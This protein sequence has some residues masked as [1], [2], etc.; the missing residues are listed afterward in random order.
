MRSPLFRAGHIPCASANGLPSH[1][2]R[3]QAHTEWATLLSRR[4][5]TRSRSGCWPAATRCSAWA[6]RR[7]EPTSWCA[8][9]GSVGWRCSPACARCQGARLTAFA[10]VALADRPGGAPGLGSTRRGA[11]SFSRITRLPRRA[12]DQSL[13]E[14]MCRTRSSGRSSRPTKPCTGRKPRR[15]RRAKRSWRASRRRATLSTSSCPPI[16]RSGVWRWAKVP[17]RSRRAGSTRGGSPR[18]RGPW[19]IGSRL[20]SVSSANATSCLP[21]PPRPRHG[22]GA[23]PDALQ[24]QSYAGRSTA[25]KRIIRW[26]TPGPPSARGDYRFW[27]VMRLDVVVPSVPEDRRRRLTPGRL[28]TL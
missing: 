15:S 18:S 1:W 21:R 24:W 3:W 12:G 27:A 25:L 23:P 26:M 16:V 19:R 2:S 4:S 20:C 7:T 5:S 13:S 11:V 6:G 8:S 9:H 17:S 22:G 14:P 28:S 10:I